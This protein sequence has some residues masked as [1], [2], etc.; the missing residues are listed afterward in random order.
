MHDV[1]HCK[2]PIHPPT[3]HNHSVVLNLIVRLS[4]SIYGT[5]FILIHDSITNTSFHYPIHPHMLFT[6][7]SLLYVLTS[8]LLTCGIID[9]LRAGEAARTAQLLLSMVDL[10]VKR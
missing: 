10:E 3:H 2:H 7:T 8:L 1:H 4:A 5:P 9:F 6:L